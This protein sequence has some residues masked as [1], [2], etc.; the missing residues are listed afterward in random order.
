MESPFFFFILLK[1][2]LPDKFFMTLFF[3]INFFFVNLLLIFSSFI[4]LAHKS[5]MIWDTYLE[6]QLGCNLTCL[7]YY[8]LKNLIYL[9]LFNA[10]K[11]FVFSSC[12]I[13]LA[14]K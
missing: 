3:K 8:V 6:S 11:A 14:T 5:F 10:L 9:Y 1:N 13:T 2:Y 12:Y 4:L 7:S